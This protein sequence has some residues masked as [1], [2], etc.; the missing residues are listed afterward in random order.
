MSKGNANG[1]VWLEPSLSVEY[2]IGFSNAEER[3]II[4]TIKTNL[5]SFKKKWNEHFSK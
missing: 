4:E 1:K 5:E 3:T 2:L